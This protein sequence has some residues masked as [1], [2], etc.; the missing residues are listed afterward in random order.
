[1]SEL[2]AL[3]LPALMTLCVSTVSSIVSILALRAWRTNILGKRQIDLAEECLLLCWQIDESIRNARLRH[4]FAK[5]R[6]NDSEDITQTRNKAIKETDQDLCTIY[7]PIEDFRAKFK[8]AEYYIGY[9]FIRTEYMKKRFSLDLPDEYKNIVT[10]LRISLGKISKKSYPPLSKPFLSRSETFTA[11]YHDAFFGVC[12]DW[13]EDEYTVRLRTA[14]LSL[15]R[16]LRPLIRPRGLWVRYI[17][18]VGDRAI[19]RFQ[20]RPQV[21]EAGYY[22]VGTAP[23][24]V[25]DPK[26]PRKYFRGFLW[27]RHP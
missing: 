9:F 18:M 20:S 25:P 3:P 27:K 26:P 11:D 1:M 8:L 14:K 22:P 4:Y 2:F 15:E 24:L 7:G 5:P 17:D 12:S 13:L 21:Y 16:R 23:K 19:D 10:E 6:E